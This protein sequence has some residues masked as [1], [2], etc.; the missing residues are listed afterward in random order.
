MNKD[1]KNVRLRAIEPE[2]LEMMYDLENDE[3]LWNVGATNVPYSRFIIHE[4]IRQTTGDIYTDKQLRLMIEVEQQV[5]GMID[6]TAFD[7]RHNRAEVG[8]VIQQPFRHQGY[9]T[10]ALQ[11]L[12]DYS[13]NVLHIHQLYAYIATDNDYSLQLFRKAGFI[14][15]AVLKDWLCLGEKYSDACFMQ[16]F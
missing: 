14:Q 6:L 1:K 16:F 7:P 8:I 2:D 13:R 4:Y 10:Q 15:T 11:Q 3:S 12:I 9:A 5:V